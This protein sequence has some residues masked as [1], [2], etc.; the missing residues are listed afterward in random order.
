VHAAGPRRHI[1]VGSR[2]D[3]FVAHVAS[4]RPIDVIDI[5]PLTSTTQNI[6]FFKADVTRDVSAF[7]QATDSLSCLHALEHFGLGRYGDAVDPD[8]WRKGWQNLEQM[9]EPRGVLYF[10]VPL[11]SHQRVEYDAH[12]VF[13]LP[14]VLQQ[15]VAPRYDVEGFS[16]VDD[17]GDLHRD[18]SLDDGA[19]RRSFDLHMGCGI[20][21]LRLR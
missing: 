9:L 14:F 5:R 13:S 15:M 6:S 2:V 4:Y 12:R 17:A 19:A 7:R 10:S 8:G 3:G 21:T 18:A 11:G 20:F 16:Y 1:D